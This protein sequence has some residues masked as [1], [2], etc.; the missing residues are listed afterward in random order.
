MNAA[1]SAP[2]PAIVEARGRFAAGRFAEGEA[3]L[4]AYIGTHPSAADAI[5]LLGACLGAQGRHAEALECIDRGLTLREPSAAALYNRAQALLALGR[6]SEARSELDRAL[7]LKPEF[8]AAWTALALAL[9][10]LADASGAERAHRQAVQLAPASAEAYYHLARFRGA[11]GRMDEAVAGYRKAL[12]LDPRLA[13]AHVD[14]GNAMRS[15]GEAATAL[16][17]YGQAWHLAPTLV[18]TANNF[19]T[20]L[21]DAGRVAEAVDV[22]ERASRL[23]PDSAQLLDGLGI[24][25]YAQ[26]RFPEAERCHRR[27]LEISPGF[28]DAEINLGNALAAQGRSHEAIAHYRAVVAR[29]PGNADAFSNLGI[30]LQEQDELEGALE[31]YS[32]ALATRAD[33]ADALNNMGFLLEQ[34]GRR[35][36]AVTLYEKALAAN[37]ASARAAYNLSLAKLAGFDFRAGWALADPAR[38]RIV[39]PVAAP[40]AF[41]IPRFG[42]DDWNRTR[43]L[44]VWREQGVGDQIL[45]ATT[46]PELEARGIAFV[47]EVDARLVASLRRAHPGWEVVAPDASPEAFRA[48][49]RQIPL[50]SLPGLVRDSRESFARQPARLLEADPGRAAEIRRRLGSAGAG[51]WVGISW[52]SFQPRA[53]RHLER[54]K[55]SALAAFAPLAARSDL[56]LLDLQYGDT[57]AER[58]AFTAAGGKLQRLDD[59]DLFNDIDGVLAA[60]EACDCIVT[61]SNVTAH[62]AGG[63]GKKT[64]LI[65]PGAAPPFHYWAADAGG[66]CL[67]YPS[68]TIVT[69]PQMRTWPDLIARVGELLDDLRP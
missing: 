9:E 39:P 25:L 27:A 35:Q 58:A 45:Y 31:A 55:S 21:R 68:V 7:T 50:G 33:H 1:A 6:A 36:D 26:G 52:R 49:D 15:R 57:A 46:L 11:A 41:P 23:R 12:S 14:L 63:L 56:R 28:D 60:I 4:R 8:A 22:L 40:R 37:P 29:S 16:E 48:C 64:F 3:I 32:R 53:R 69:A 20:A 18:E 59:L 51:R 5:E 10:A 13:A 19:A 43:R 44:A 47:V 65:Y 30:A 34:Q 17:H 24:A 61:T 67:W 38:F 66:R 42:P 2:A 62:F 54:R